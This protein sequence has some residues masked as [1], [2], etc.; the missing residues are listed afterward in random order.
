MHLNICR[1][2]TTSADFV[3][4]VKD[5]L[6]ARATTFYSKNFVSFQIYHNTIHKKNRKFFF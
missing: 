5:K 4:D 2:N 1:H 3:G 6:K